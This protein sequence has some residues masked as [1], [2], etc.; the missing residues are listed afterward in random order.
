VLGLAGMASILALGGM[1]YLLTRKPR[2]H[3]A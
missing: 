2:T 1:L 3:A